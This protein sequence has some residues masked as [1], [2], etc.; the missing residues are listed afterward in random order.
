M[1]RELWTR[2]DLRNALTAVYVA[3]ALAPATT[4]GTE[5]ASFMNGFKTALMSLALSFGLPSLSLPN[6]DP[7]AFFAAVA[8]A[9]VEV[10]DATIWNP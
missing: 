10:R 5:Q 4:T 6:A 3:T 8:E 2:T 1:Q 9:D 7:K